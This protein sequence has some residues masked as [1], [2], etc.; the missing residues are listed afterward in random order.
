DLRADPNT[1]NIVYTL[2]NA[3]AV[4]ALMPETSEPYTRSVIEDLSA[5]HTR[6]FNQ[7]TG[8]ES[9][10]WIKNTWTALA[11]DR[12]DITV[13]YFNHETDVSPQPSVILTITGKTTPAEIVVLGGHQDSINLSGPT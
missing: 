9:A 5:F 2:D 12:S 6:R 3:A 8:L 1:Q 7:P 4:N 11:A 10:A 13:Q